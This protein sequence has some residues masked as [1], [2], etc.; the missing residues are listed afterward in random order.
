VPPAPVPRQTLIEIFGRLSNVSVPWLLPPSGIHSCFAAPR[1][2][3]FFQLVRLVSRQI[4]RTVERL[5]VKTLSFVFMVVNE[6]APPCPCT[7]LTGTPIVTSP[8]TAVCNQRSCPQTASRRDRAF[9]ASSPPSTEAPKPIGKKEA[10]NQLWVVS[11]VELGAF[12]SQVRVHT[13]SHHASCQLGHS[14]G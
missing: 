7:P 11:P 2:V 8:L 14:A 9:T 13:S 12:G 4:C 10:G 5:F 6:E 3:C 1:F